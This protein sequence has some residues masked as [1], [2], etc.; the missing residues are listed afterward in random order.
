MKKIAA[1]ILLLIYFT[2]ST[3]F[4]INLHY[5]MD[6]VAS[7]EVGESHAD[8]CGKCGMPLSDKE[9]CCRNEV[10]VVKLHQDLVPTYSVVFELA[11]LPVLIAT[12]HYITAPFENGVQHDNYWLHAPPLISK[13]D[14]YLTNRVFRL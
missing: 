9:D 5:C 14:T 13:Q 7:V 3:G 2:V 1:A 6:K 10:K 8:E 11:S 12:V 4:V